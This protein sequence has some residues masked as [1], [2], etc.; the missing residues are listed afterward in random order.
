ML[1]EFAQFIEDRCRSIQK[2]G[3]F[4]P[5]RP[6]GRFLCLLSRITGLTKLSLWIAN[7][8]DDFI[9]WSQT[10]T[11]ADVPEDTEVKEY[12]IRGARSGRGRL[13]GGFVLEQSYFRAGCLPMIVVACIICCVA[14]SVG[15]T[16]Y[17][18]WESTRYV[19]VNNEGKIELETRYTWR[20]WGDY[21]SPITHVVDDEDEVQRL[22]GPELYRQIVQLYD[23]LDGKDYYPP[24]ASGSWQWDRGVPLKRI[25]SAFNGQTK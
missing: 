2:S 7:D 9:S 1:R 14:V 3:L 21:T 16:Y 15:S 10:F 13:L 22:I 17:F 5:F 12:P 25:E 20:Y 8:I 4:K 19:D 11:A 23:A 6:I 18:G 24:N